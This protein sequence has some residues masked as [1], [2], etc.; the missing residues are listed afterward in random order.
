MNSAELHAEGQTAP[1][2]K[3]T[4][5]SAV[6]C[7]VEMPIP[8]KQGTLLKVGLWI[9]KDKLW[10]N[11]KVASSRPGFGTTTAA[12]QPLRTPRLR[13]SNPGGLDLIRLAF[14][15]LFAKV[16]PDGQTDR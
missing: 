1:W 2:G 16:S 5:L 6:G 7:F 9:Q 12:V 10:L 13:P 11:G 15:K 4:D 14:N 3:A 8:L